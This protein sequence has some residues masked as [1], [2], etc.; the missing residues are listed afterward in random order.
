MLGNVKTLKQAWDTITKVFAS[1]TRARIMHLK[2]CLARSSKVNKTII[3]YLHGIKSISDELA[4]INSPLDDVDL[5]IHTMN[6]L[7]S[8][9][10]EI[11]ASLRT[12][13]NPINFGALHDLLAAFDNYLKL[14]DSFDVS[15]ASPNVAYKRK[16]YHFKRG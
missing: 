4:I 16:H 3:E 1:R 10:L 13:E 9:Y 6:G 7:G 12:R 14:D 5:V 8:K 2:E 15:I 11:A